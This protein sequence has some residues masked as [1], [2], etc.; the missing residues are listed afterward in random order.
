MPRHFYFDPAIYQVPSIAELRWEWSNVPHQ[1]ARNLIAVEAQY[2]EFHKYVLASLRHRPVEG[3]EGIILGLS[4][5]A[6]A[7]KSATLLSASI[8]E[9]ALRAH[10]EARNYPLDP[11]PR[12]RTFGNVLRAWKQNDAPRP[13]V[14]GIWPT[15][16][17]IHQGRNNIH[18]YAAAE[19]GADF[20]DVVESEERFLQATDVALGVIK[21]V[22][23]A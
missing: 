20:Y 8:A 4:V 11:N 5:R 19:A 22:E 6:G 16:E 18:L 10:A 13:D 23:S 14:A 15:L 12:R 9:A 3:G 7:I 17:E 1:A 21:G 2:L